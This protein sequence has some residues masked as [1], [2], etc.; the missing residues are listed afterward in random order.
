[1]LFD[2]DL[3]TFTHNIGGIFGR[4]AGFLGQKAVSLEG[5]VG[6]KLLEMA[7]T[8]VTPSE[9]GVHIHDCRTY[10]TALH[11]RGRSTISCK[12]LYSCG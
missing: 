10:M 3:I 2:D 6:E 9:A 4:C 8:K 12:L 11:I 1:M 7:P 5:E